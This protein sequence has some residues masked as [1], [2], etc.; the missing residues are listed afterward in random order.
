[1]ASYIGTTLGNYRILATLGQGGTAKVYKAY[2][3]NLDRKVAVKVLPL[4]FAADRSF[5]ERLWA[6]SHQMRML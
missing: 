6:I 4:W 5:V 1:M 2:Q 3:E